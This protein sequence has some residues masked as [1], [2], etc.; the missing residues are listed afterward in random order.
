MESVA[1]CTAAAGAVSVAVVDECAGVGLVD[2]AVVR[3]VRGGAGC[4]T[5]SR[6]RAGWADL[7]KRVGEPEG[8]VATLKS[9]IV[10][11]VAALGGC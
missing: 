4:R 5:P 2:D 11:R 7:Q 6:E 3:L 8:V 1:N 10:S 9:V